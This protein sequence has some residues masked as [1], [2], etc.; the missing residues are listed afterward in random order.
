MGCSG[1]NQ[2]EPWPPNFT[3]FTASTF[4]NNILTVVYHWAAPAAEDLVT[5]NH[6]KQNRWIN[7]FTP[8]DF[9]RFTTILAK[10]SLILC[11]FFHCPPAAAW[12]NPQRLCDYLKN[13]YF[14]T[15]IFGAWLQ[16]SETHTRKKKPLQTFWNS[17]ETWWQ[18]PLTN[19]CCAVIYDL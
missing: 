2:T 7:H 12:W 15:E 13:I 9:S 19:C 10:L 3:N 6:E 16:G 5:S 1:P 14:C 4:Q 18:M 17:L 8:T 11:T